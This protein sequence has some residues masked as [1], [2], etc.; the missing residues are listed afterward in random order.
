MRLGTV[1]DGTKL[2]GA[3]TQ[4]VN[5]PEL[6][7]ME[8]TLEFRR[9]RFSPTRRTNPL[10]ADKAEEERET[11]GERVVENIG[12]ARPGG[13]GENST[14]D[15]K[16]AVE[17][18]RGKINHRRRKAGPFV[19]LRGAKFASSEEG[20]PE[21]DAWQTVP[22]RLIRSVNRRKNVFLLAA[23]LR[24]GGAHCRR[25]DGQARSPRPRPEACRPVS[26]ADRVSPTLRAAIYFH[27][28]S[29]ALRGTKYPFS[30]SGIRCTQ[31]PRPGGPEKR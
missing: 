26:G 25:T 31:V 7:S 5:Y 3:P 23:K 8:P 22:R 24:D 16:A 17:E 20:T 28:R 4:G 2:A 12:N 30:E 27:T 18:D 19:F 1:G 15:R 10:A 11:R 21:T 9:D 6:C 13:S 14:R 29:P